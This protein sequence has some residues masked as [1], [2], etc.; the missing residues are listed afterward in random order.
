M[1]I[2]VRQRQPLFII[3][4]LFK[5]SY[6]DLRRIGVRLDF[7]FSPFLPSSRDCEVCSSRL[8]HN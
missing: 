1:I 6:S 7:P 4:T 3:S 2:Q 8:R 5:V